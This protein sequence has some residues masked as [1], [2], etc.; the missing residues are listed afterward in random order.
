MRKLSLF[1]IL[2]LLCSSFAFAQEKF[3]IKGQVRSRLQLDNKDFNSDVNPNSFTELRTRL[4]VKFTPEENIAGL[5]QIQDSRLF[6]G[7]TNTLSDSKM[8][9]LHQAYFCIQEIFG[10]P[11]N[12]KTGRMELAYGAQ[13]LIGSVGWHNVGRSF[14]GGVAKLSTEKVDFDFISARLNESGLA[15]DVQ[16]S[17]L[18]SV[19]GNLKLVKNYKLQPY[20]ISETILDSDFSRNTLGLFVSGKHG[21]FS[22]EVEAAYQLG[23]QAKDIDIAAYML[24]VNLAYKFNTSIKPVLGAGVDY[25]SGDDGK[26]AGKYKVFNTLYATNHKFYGFMDYFLNIP[27]HTYGKGLMD[28]HAKTSLNPGEKVKVAGAFHLFNSVA[29][30]VEGNGHIPSPVSVLLVPN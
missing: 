24:T 17:H 25:L 4:T 21:G 15:E 16:D 22:H 30:S 2:T 28:I 19:Y 12:L 20:I 27:K 10:L 23:T 7:E 3:T 13:R 29:V 14:D 18:S 5:I 9:D 26:D 8:L 1:I 6:G 11:V